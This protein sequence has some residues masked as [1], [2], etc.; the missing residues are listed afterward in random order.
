MT[1]G[2][3]VPDAA[4]RLRGAVSAP[5]I[6]W[7]GGSAA[8]AMGRGARAVF[9]RR[10]RRHRRDARR[11]RDRRARRRRL[12]AS[13]TSGSARRSGR[14]GKCRASRSASRPRELPPIRSSTTS[15]TA[16][17]AAGRGE[18]ADAV[19]APGS[20]KTSISTIWNYRSSYRPTTGSTRCAYVLPTLLDQTLDAGAYE[21]VIADSRSDD[22]TDA[23]VRSTTRVGSAPGACATCPV[24]TRARGGA[25]RGHRGGPGAGRALHRC[26]HHRVARPARASRARSPAASGQSGGGGRLRAASAIARRLPAAARRPGTPA[27]RSIRRRAPTAVV[28]LFPHRQRVRRGA[29]T[30]SGRRIRRIVHRIRSRRPRTRL[31]AREKRRRNPL[32]SRG[33]QLSL[34]PGAVRRADRAHGARRRLDRPLLSQASGFRRESEPRDDARLARAPLAARSGEAGAPS[35]RASRRVRRD[36]AEEHVAVHRA[37]DRISISLRHRREAR[38]ARAHGA[39]KRSTTPRSAR[40]CGE[41]TADRVGARRTSA[42]GSNG[43]RDHGGF[44]FIDVRDRFGITQTVFDPSVAPAAAATAATLRVRGRDRGPRRRPPTA[45]GDREQRS[46]RPVRSRSPDR[47]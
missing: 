21:I 41:L 45:R 2:N 17:A 19:R 8:A 39:S 27:S 6:T 10:H 1:Y 7:L 5:N 23:F 11:E 36:A 34:A 47:T 32:R 3:D 24:R 29:T 35:D 22:G 38:A 9:G 18:N 42:A 28:A 12:R 25:Q 33:D 30:S 26:G 46:S 13:S 44:I 16:A 43:A 4:A 14:L 20:L 31:S 15:S 40:H 37:T